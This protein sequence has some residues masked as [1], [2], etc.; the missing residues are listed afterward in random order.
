MEFKSMVYHPLIEQDDSRLTRQWSPRAIAQANFSSMF[1]RTYFKVIQISI[2]PYSLFSDLKYI[3]HF[4][5]NSIERGLPLG[6][7]GAKLGP[8]ILAWNILPARRQHLMLKIRQRELVNFVS[9]PTR[10]S[11]S[12]MHSENDSFQLESMRDILRQNL[13]RGGV[14]R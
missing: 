9:E 1:I 2:N 5:K 14:L 3:E 13:W 11:M 10:F 6:E 4:L 12:L 7:I 8:Y